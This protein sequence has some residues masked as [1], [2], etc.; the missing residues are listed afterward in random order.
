MMGCYNKNYRQNHSDLQ[1]PGKASD[2][3]VYLL[4]NKQW[5]NFYHVYVVD[6]NIW[7]S[8]RLIYIEQGGGIF[9]KECLNEKAIN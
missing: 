1:F 2:N 9:H 5:G 3:N 4:F 6:K 7:E 8:K